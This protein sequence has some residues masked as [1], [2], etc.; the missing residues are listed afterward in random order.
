MNARTGREHGL[1]IRAIVEPEKDGTWF[2]H[3]L[4]VDYYADGATRE[5]AQERFE[6][7]L[8]ATIVEQLKTTGTIRELLKRAPDEYWE[9]L[10]DLI[11]SD[12]VFVTEVLIEFESTPSSKKRQ[13]SIEFA[14]PSG[15]DLAFV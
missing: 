10:A 15:A 1:T 6:R 8:V 4:D 7:G 3:G 5:E 11:A 9:R 12:C 14:S 2:A 13:H